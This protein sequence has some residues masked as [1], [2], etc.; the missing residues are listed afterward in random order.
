MCF[1]VLFANKKRVR[2]RNKIR[3]FA[4]K[5][6]EI[7]IEIPSVYYVISDIHRLIIIDVNMFFFYE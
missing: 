1:C 6:V 3:F 5:K 7:K 2:Q 4:C